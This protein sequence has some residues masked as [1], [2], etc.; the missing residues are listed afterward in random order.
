M[1]YNYYLHLRH[2]QH[3]YTMV[4]TTDMVDIEELGK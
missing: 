3:Y 1:Y 2:T 4:G